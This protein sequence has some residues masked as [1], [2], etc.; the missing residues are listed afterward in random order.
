MRFLGCF[1]ACMAMVC[2]VVG[3]VAAIGAMHERYGIF[4]ALMTWATPVSLLMAFFFWI[5]DDEEPAE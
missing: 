2:L 5:G 3:W 4:A 1:A